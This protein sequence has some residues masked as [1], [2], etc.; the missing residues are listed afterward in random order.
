M[1]DV[2]RNPILR[3]GDYIKDLFKN[4]TIGKIAEGGRMFTSDYLF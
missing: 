1:N 3:V 2:K 4:F